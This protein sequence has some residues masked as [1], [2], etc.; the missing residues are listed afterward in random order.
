[1][2][3]AEAAI[4]DFKSMTPEQLE[5]VAAMAFDSDLGMGL[6]PFL[7]PGLFDVLLYG[8]MT[9]QYMTW[10]QFSRPG[11]RRLLK[12]A[13]HWIF[14]ASTV[15]TICAVVFEMQ[16]FV[17]GFGTFTSFLDVNWP[18]MW[19]VVGWTMSSVIQA[20]YTER[21]YRLNNR[22]AY[23]LGLCTALILAEGALAV[24]CAIKIQK[25]ILTMLEA[26][27][28]ET[29]VRSWQCVTLATDIVI[30]SSLAWGLHRSRTGWSGTDALVT[31]L[32]LITLETQLA[33][34]VVMLG[35]VIQF[36]ILPTSSMGLFW[37][38]MIPKTYMAVVEARRRKP[39]HTTDTYVESFQMPEH[40]QGLN[41]DLPIND[42]KE[43]SDVESIENLDY[44]QNLSKRN[45]NGQKE[46]D[47]I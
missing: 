43:A 44:A 40:R 22:N 26:A 23:L 6:G 4:P 25:T 12:W 14:F 27:V 13:T 11:D 3:A 5:A 19:P 46:M 29:E 45:L 47:P 17:Y 35:F 31:R 2:S 8:V 38:L 32:L 18:T 1:M 34:T 16:K 15:W 33:P 42:I 24:H 30:T 9:Q 37:D 21:A 36:S 41:R 28:I 10:W 7:L 39:T 20:F